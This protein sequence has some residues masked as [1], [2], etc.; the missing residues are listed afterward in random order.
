MKDQAT[1]YYKT[2]KL[3]LAAFSHNISSYDY[4]L[5]TITGSIT[6]NQISPKYIT[7]NILVIVIEIQ[8][9]I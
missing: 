5:K 4:R 9:S 6:I 2:S 1:L 7:L 8:V 3:T